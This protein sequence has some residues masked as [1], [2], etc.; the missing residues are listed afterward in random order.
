[1]YSMIPLQRRGGSIF[2]YMDDIER[3]FFSNISGKDQFRCDISEKD[4]GYQ[5]QAELPGFDKNDIHVEVDGELL[6]I[7]AT[8]NEENSEKD[9]NGSYIRRERRYG[10]FSR[11]FNAEGIDVDKIQA[12]YKNGVLTLDLPKAKEE[13]KESRRI[14]INSGEGEKPAQLAN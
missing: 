9:E 14:E 7:S 13:V 3:S 6:T 8:H 12:N 2:S 4:G 11:S 10:S 5:L 1:M